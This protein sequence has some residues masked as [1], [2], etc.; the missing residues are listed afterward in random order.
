MINTHAQMESASQ[1]RDGSVYSPGSRA[2]VVPG[3]IPSIVSQLVATVE[4]Q[5]RVIDELRSIL[6]RVRGDVKMGEASAAQ[7]S[8]PNTLVYYAEAT[9]AQSNIIATLIGELNQYI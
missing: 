7:P 8:A 1:N 4:G 9:T 2:E 3:P 5:A 6:Y